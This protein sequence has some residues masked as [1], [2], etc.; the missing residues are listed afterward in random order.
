LVSKNGLKGTSIAG[1]TRYTELINNLRTI[2][3]A[4]NTMTKKLLGVKEFDKLEEALQ[5]DLLHR[6]GV[7]VGKRKSGKQTVILFQLYGFY[8]EVYYKQYRKVIDHIVTSDETDILQPYLDQI[9]V[10]DLNKG[11]H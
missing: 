3:V 9:Q 5:F 7:Y 2:F 4:T 6:D 10:R 1:W 8:V 11:K